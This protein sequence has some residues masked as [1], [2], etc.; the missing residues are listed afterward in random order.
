MPLQLYMSMEPYIKKRG[1]FTAKEKG[2]KNQAEI[3]K[4]LEAVWE[5]KEAAVIHCKGRQK[6]DDPV[7]KGN[8]S[9]DVAARQTAWGQ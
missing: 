9:A 3:L 5:P 6:G 4:L 2:I 7:T 8:H 1:L